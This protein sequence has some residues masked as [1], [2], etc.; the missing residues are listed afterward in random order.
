MRSY[1]QAT[2]AL[3]IGRDTKWVDNVLSRH[4]IAGVGFGG[5]G[6]T[7]RVP[8]D[9]AVRLAIVSTLE[10]S[11]GIPI[12]RAAAIANSRQTEARSISAGP[13][14]SLSVD[15]EVLGISVAAALA[16]VIEHHVPARRGRPRRKGVA[17]P[18]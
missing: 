7:R 13:G 18:R 5:R 16:E 15:F 11:F 8:V 4:A 12:G 1:H 14:V 3:A 9:A 6:V 2:V 10:R 17:T